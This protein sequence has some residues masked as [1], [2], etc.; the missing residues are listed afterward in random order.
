VAEPA[1]GV[2]WKDAAKDLAKALAKSGASASLR[3]VVLVAVSLVLNLAFS[4]IFFFLAGLA[5]GG[6]GSLLA[7][8]LALVPFAPF[9]V[10]AVV[11]AQKQG[12]MRLVAAAVESQAPT[13]AK[14]GSHYLGGFLRERHGALKETRVGAGFDK[15]WQQYLKSRDASWPVRVVIGQLTSRVPLGEIIDEL[16]SEG[17]P[18]DDLPREAMDRVIKRVAQERLHPS[19]L[20]IV[21]L[22]GGNIVWFPIITLLIKG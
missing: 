15:G 1:H 8:P 12:V 11:L 3:G 18:S 7:L 2:D 6:H 16:G 10:L 21:L 4:V 5:G 14:L 13:I 20:P 17:V 19:W 9:V 22:F